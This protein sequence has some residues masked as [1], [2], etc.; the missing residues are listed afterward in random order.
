MDVP[1][2]EGH[3]GSFQLLVIMNKGAMNILEKKIFFISLGKTPKCAISGSYSKSTFS[4]QG[5]C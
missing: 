3:L 1:Q 2:F 5:N 4:F